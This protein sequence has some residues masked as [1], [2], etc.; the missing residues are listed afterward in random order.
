MLKVL[1]I[2]SSLYFLLFCFRNILQSWMVTIKAEK[3][4]INTLIQWLGKVWMDNQNLIATG[5]VLSKHK[6]HTILCIMN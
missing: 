6:E 5:R 3:D 2:F 4:L 1:V